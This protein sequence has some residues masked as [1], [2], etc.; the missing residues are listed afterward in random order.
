MGGCASSLTPEEKRD[1]AHSRSLEEQNARDASRD[2]TTIKMLLL[3]A[4]ESGKSTIFKQM[5]LLY[6][7]AGFGDRMRWVDKIH[8]NAVD[9][10]KAICAPR[11]NPQRPAP[12]PKGHRRP[13]RAIRHASPEHAALTPAVAAAIAR[14]WADGG[15][16]QAWER[17]S[18]YQVIESNELYLA[19][20]AALALP[21][22]VPTNADILASRVRTCGIHEETFEYEKLEFNIIDAAFRP[23]HLSAAAGQKNERR[24]WIHCFD[25][26]NA[27][28]FVV[29]LS[30]Y[31][32]M[33]FEDPT[34]NRMV[35]S[36]LLFDNICNNKFFHATAMILF[37]NKTDLFRSKLPKKPI[38]AVVPWSDY[39]GGDYA[40]GVGYFRNKFVSQNRRAAKDIY[41]H[42]TCATDTANIK[43]VFNDSTD[44]I[45]KFNLEASGM[46]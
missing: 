7:A 30:E 3:G 20:V 16:Q 31:D 6:T 17:R 37:L 15:I 41:T 23:P 2:G 46:M 34:Q 45:L 43:E 10:I 18:E 32:Q 8:S 39:A 36:L 27:V 38:E 42:E 33:M 21:G 14:L 29:A 35:D 28:V 26:V 12:H 44:I 25:N 5:Q 9:A 1:L 22:Y 11:A 24:K 40:A 13:W 19:N 4:G